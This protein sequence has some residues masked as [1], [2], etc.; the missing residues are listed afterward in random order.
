MGPSMASPRPR[1]LADARGASRCRSRLGAG[2]M[3]A[4]SLRARFGRSPRPTRGTLSSPVR[5]SCSYLDPKEQS[6]VNYKLDT[7]RSVYKKLTGKEA[8]F[9]F[10][11]VN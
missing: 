3:R 6:N 11:V 5:P 10:P 4:Q 9:E 7:F 1:A 2:E 8:H